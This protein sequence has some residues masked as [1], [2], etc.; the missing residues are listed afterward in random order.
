MAL[1]FASVIFFVYL[2]SRKGLATSPS[3]TDV[4]QEDTLKMAFIDACFGITKSG[5]FHTPK[6]RWC[7]R[8]SV[9]MLISVRAPHRAG[10]LNIS[11][12]DV[13]VCS[14]V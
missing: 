14:C 7:N 12:V 5:K 1:L 4:K 3:L 8:R 10:G 6:T 13:I 2:C 11:G 9:G